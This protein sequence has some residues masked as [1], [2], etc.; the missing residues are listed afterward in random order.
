MLF[1]VSGLKNKL[2]L[3]YTKTSKVEGDVNETKKGNVGIA[4]FRD[5]SEN[6]HKKIDGK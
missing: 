2:I 1:V 3:M 4:T 6:K 5:P